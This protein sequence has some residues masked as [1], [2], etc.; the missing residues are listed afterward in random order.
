[1]I[2]DE[3]HQKLVDGISALVLRDLMTQ[4]EARKIIAFYKDLPASVDEAAL[5]SIYKDY[6][7]NEEGNDDTY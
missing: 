4:D 2:T 7:L 6:G 1:M 5:H 3:P